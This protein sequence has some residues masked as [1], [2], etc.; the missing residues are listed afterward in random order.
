MTVLYYSC[1]S[2]LSSCCYPFFFF[3]NDTATTEIYTFPTRRSS[4]LRIGSKKLKWVKWIVIIAPLIA[5]FSDIMSW[6]LAREFENGVYIVIVSG[7]VMTI[8]FF[9]QMSISAYQIIKS[10]TV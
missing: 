2:C 9:T 5:M 10:F 1:L 4:D 8:A 3:F 7:I 6:N